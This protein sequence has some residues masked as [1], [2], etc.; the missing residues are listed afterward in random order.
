MAEFGKVSHSLDEDDGSLSPRAFKKRRTSG[1]DTFDASSFP[2][3]EENNITAGNQ[4]EE[5]L[6]S[7]LDTGALE[8]GENL[9]GSHDQGENGTDNGAVPAGNPDPAQDVAAVISNI[10]GHSERV[11]EQFA[12]SQKE[13]QETNDAGA[14]ASKGVVYLKA[15]SHL[16]IQSLP[17]LDN[18]VGRDAT[19][20]RYL[21]AD[22]S[23]IN[24][25]PRS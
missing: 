3:K 5:E 9:N 18:L 10:I 2:T 25:R 23:P 1:P 8:A 20:P 12:A 22:C 15:N 24:S 11:E 7:A 17:I 16:K 21:D 13:K 14:P 4:I 6:A 19:L